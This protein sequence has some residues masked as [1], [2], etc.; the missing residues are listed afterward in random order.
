MTEERTRAVELTVISGLSGA[1]RSEAAKAFEDLGWFVIDNLP[2]ALIE[3]MLSLAL[4]PAHGLKR[5]A[6]VIDARGESFFE[7]A[8]SELERLRGSAADI[9][10]LPVRGWSSVSIASGR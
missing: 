8:A 1:G 2:P 10:W 4:T 7:E 9:P 6:L 5:I 3:R